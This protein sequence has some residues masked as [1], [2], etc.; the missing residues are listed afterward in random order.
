MADAFMLFSLTFK[1]PSMPLLFQQ[2][3]AATRPAPVT[4][5]SLHLAG[6]ERPVSVLRWRVRGAVVMDCVLIIQSSRRPASQHWLYR[7][8]TRTHKRTLTCT[9]ARTHTRC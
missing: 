9:H 5:P 7:T 8:H 2:A 1:A 3:G 4:P 6:A